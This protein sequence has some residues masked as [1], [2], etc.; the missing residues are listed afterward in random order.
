MRRLMMMTAL[1]AE[2]IRGPEGEGAGGGG[3]G[4]GDAGDA[5]AGAGDGEG[6]AAAGAS[7]A[8]E[9][10][11]GGSAGGES[12][13]AGADENAGG[14]RPWHEREGALTGPEREWLKARGMLTDDTEGVLLC[15]I[16]GHMAAETR[17]GKP[18]DA[19]ME[20]PAKGQDVH[21]WL[22]AN[23]AML[24][25]PDAP[26]GYEIEKPELPKGLEWNGELEAGFRQLAHEHAMTPAQVQAGAK[27]FAEFQARQFETVGA[28]LQEASDAM[29]Q[30]LERDWGDQYPAKIQR[31]QQAAQAV[32]QAA[33]LDSD[34]IMRIGE[35]LAPKIGDAGIMRLF[36]AIG[37]MAGDDGFVPG[38]GGGASGMGMTPAEA[39]AELQ[40]FTSPAGDYGKAYAAGKVPKDLED[41]RQMLMKLAA[42]S[43]R[44]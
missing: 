34:A 13:G 22:R 24:G 9:G 27:F 39:K 36:A 42:P 43:A 40:R 3:T 2:L 1:W 7:G 19:L 25:L 15:A 12:G 16:R 5:Q 35:L 10:G 11:A 41:R 4:G 23:S 18:A 38:G 33:G 30:A 26:E 29:R 6:G 37:D 28:Q 20:K 32:G 14:G 21:D 17:L 8:G 44:R 31:A